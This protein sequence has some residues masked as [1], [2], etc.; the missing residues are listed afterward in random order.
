[1]DKITFLWESKEA[2][3]GTPKFWENVFSSL[4]TK[5]TGEVDFR[6]YLVALSI[7]GSDSIESKLKM[8]F[9]MYDLDKNGTIEKEEFDQILSIMVQMGGI[10]TNKEH[11]QG[12]NHEELSNNLFNAL[13][14]N[15][16]GKIQLEEWVKVGSENEEI[17]RI[18]SGY[19][20]EGLFDKK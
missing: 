17:N 5:H 13:D 7:A 15:G 20:V 2:F 11:I 4:D 8:S 1:M 9:T 3:G 10:S 18:L 12:K 14:V 19:L 6:D 16:D